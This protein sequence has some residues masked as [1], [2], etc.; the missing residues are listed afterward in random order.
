[1]TFSKEEKEILK[2]LVENELRIIKEQ[3][4]PAFIMEDKPGYI[5]MEGKY[6]DFLESL[7]KK[8]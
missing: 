3:G 6:E 2:A 7:L 5:A 8:L 1:M 4:K